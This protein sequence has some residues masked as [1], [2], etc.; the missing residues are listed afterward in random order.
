MPRLHREPTGP[1]DDEADMLRLA[2]PFAMLALAGLVASMV[3]HACSLLGLPSPFGAA[4]WGLH[5]GIFVIWLPAVLMSQKLTRG[6]RQADFW[7]A[8]LRG[9]PPWMRTAFYVIFAYGIINFI[10]GI[11]LGPDSEADQFRLFSGHWMI[12]YFAGFAMLWSAA[13]LST[14][15][16]P[17]CPRGHECSPFARFC[18]ECGE[19]LPPPPIG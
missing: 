10:L 18:E 14:A 8:A 4:S 17:T 12:F 3:V 13:Q 5:I 19:P 7:K 2:R 16:T 1:D 9:C 11:A 6:A 15:P